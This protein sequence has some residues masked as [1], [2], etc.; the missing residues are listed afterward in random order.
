MGN[1]FL[2]EIQEN[3]IKWVKEM[4]KTVQ[5]LKIEIETT[6]KTQV[7]E[8][9][10]M[11]NLGRKIGTTITSINNRIQEMEERISDVKDTID[12]ID[13]SVKENA[14]SKK[15][16]FKQKTFRKFGTL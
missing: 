1:T 5:N 3:T 14:K 12:E 8:T 2:K 4:N 10:V 13:T 9:L 15:H 16:F 11:E 6:K 7:E